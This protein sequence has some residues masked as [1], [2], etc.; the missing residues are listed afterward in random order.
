MKFLIGGDPRSAFPIRDLL[1]TRTRISAEFGL[2]AP[3][4]F[5]NGRHFSMSVDLPHLPFRAETRSDRRFLGKRNGPESLGRAHP[6][7]H[8]HIRTPNYSSPTPHTAP[9]HITSLRARRNTGMPRSREVRHTH[10]RVHTPAPNYSPQNHCVFRA[11]RKVHRW[12]SGG[13][14]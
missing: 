14:R 9:Q 12:G 8:T 6:R 4:P 7:A 13:Y 10:T 3:D 5:C 1:W 2:L 11:P